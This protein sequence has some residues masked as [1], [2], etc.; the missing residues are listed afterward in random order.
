[1]RAHLLQGCLVQIAVKETVN[2]EVSGF[3]NR[4]LSIDAAVMNVAGGL[5]VA[6]SHGKHRHLLARKARRLHV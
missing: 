4:V 1:M 3:K 6:A 2:G 5:L